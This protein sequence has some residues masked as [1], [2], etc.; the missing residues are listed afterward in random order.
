MTARADCLLD[1]PATT[2]MGTVTLLAVN[3]FVVIATMPFQCSMQICGAAMAKAKTVGR[4]SAS[5]NSSNWDLPPSDRLLL[6]APRSH[7]Q[8]EERRVSEGG[9]HAGARAASLPMPM[10][11]ASTSRACCAHN[12]RRAHLLQGAH[13]PATFTRM[14]CPQ[15]SPPACSCPPPAPAAAA[16]SAALQPQWAQ[17][18]APQTRRAPPA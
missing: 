15:H 9:A 1:I 2:Q 14:H 10:K 7:S 18:P 11:G 4:S 13:T 17:P 6:G 5:R 8:D 12:R 16:S 3:P